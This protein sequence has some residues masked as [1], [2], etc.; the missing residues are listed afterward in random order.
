[1]NMQRYAQAVSGCELVRRIGRVTRFYG[2]VLEASGPDAF[3]GEVCEVHSRSHAAPVLAEVVGLRDGTVLLMPYGELR[4]IGL[5]SE[6]IARGQSLR[7]PAGEALLGRVIDAFCKPLDGRPAPRTSAMINLHRDAINPLN[8]PPI[9]QVLES[10][11][12]A[13]DTLLTIGKGQRIGIFS[14]SGVGKSTL[15]GMLAR[16]V[17]SDVNVIALVGERGREVREFIEQSLG[18]AGLKR[19][20][21]VVSTSEQ[22]AL[23]RCNAAFAATALAEHFR[24]QGADV[25]LIMDSVSR[26]AMAQREIGL[27]IGEPPTARGYTPSVFASLPRLLERCGTTDAGSITAFYTVLAEGDDFTGDPIVDAARSVLDG[28]IVLSRELADQRHFPAIDILKSISR[29]MPLLSTPGE[30]ELAQRAIRTLNQLT[31]SR[32]LIEIGAYKS[33]AN[34]ELDRALQLAP[35]LERFLCQ[36]MTESVARS[37]A[38]RELSTIFAESKS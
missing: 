38:L 7:V 23:M 37:D 27:A 3:L 25:A 19:S 8:R 10:G 24:A 28:H 16:N 15:L 26:F 20:V 22:A 29:L 31:R 33:G 35:R 4:G 17:R 6:V 2:L 18:P 9:R 21:L 13:I 36:G 5:G 12:R 30:Q 34:A 14:G 32:D 1:M 11:V